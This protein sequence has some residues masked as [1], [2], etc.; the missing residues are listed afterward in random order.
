M[1]RYLPNMPGAAKPDLAPV[2]LL[3]SHARIDRGFR[4]V[5]E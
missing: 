3:G 2:T 1:I 4:P 5:C